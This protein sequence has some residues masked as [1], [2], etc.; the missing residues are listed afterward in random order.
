MLEKFVEPDANADG[1]HTVDTAQ[2]RLGNPSR[3]PCSPDRQNSVLAVIG[4]PNPEFSR[5]DQTT[6]SKGGGEI[7][8]SN[9]ETG[10]SGQECRTSN[11]SESFRQHQKESR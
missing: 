2:D 5:T 11:R 4:E 8:R 6:R 1:R 7:S 3:L 10:R 9:Q